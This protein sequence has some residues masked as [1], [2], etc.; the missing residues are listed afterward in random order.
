MGK[1][2]LK[3]NDVEIKNQ[4]F[5]FS[6]STSSIFDVNINTIVISEEFPCT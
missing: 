1:E 5:N 4:R 6:G 3:F 2:F